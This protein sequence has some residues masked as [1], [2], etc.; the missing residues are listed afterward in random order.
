MQP[1]VHYRFRMSLPVEPS[2]S[3]E[4]NI[5]SGYSNVKDK[6]LLFDFLPLA[7]LYTFCS[8]VY[9]FFCKRNVQ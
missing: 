2:F 4:P 5:R 3:H 9:E 8:S 7:K 6:N 1:E